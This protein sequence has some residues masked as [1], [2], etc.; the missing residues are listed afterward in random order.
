MADPLPVIPNEGRA[1]WL[2][3]GSGGIGGA[4]TPAF[5]LF[6]ADVD[7]VLASTW[8][9]FTEADFS[10]YARVG[11]TLGPIFI[12]GDNLQEQDWSPAVWTHNGGGVGNLIYGWLLLHDAGGGSPVIM[13]GQNFN[14]ARSMTILTDSIPV[15]V[16]S[17]F[18]PAA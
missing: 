14:P 17:L 18:D 16:N 15:I 5:V 6:A 10:G 8:A 2:A 7:V 13:A 1:I 4:G 12:N 11:I 3:S 9:D